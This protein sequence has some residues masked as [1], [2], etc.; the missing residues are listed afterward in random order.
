LKGL[1]NVLSEKEMKN[2]MGG[3]GSGG[4]Y[5]LKCHNSTTSCWVSSCP[6]NR[7]EAEMM[8]RGSNCGGSY[9]SISCS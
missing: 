2:V 9:S 7:S 5:S 8:C 4:S 1:T 3:S 6:D